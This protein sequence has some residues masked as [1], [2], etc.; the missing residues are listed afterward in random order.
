MPVFDPHGA[1]SDLLVGEGHPEVEIESSPGT[2]GEVSHQLAVIAKEDP[3][4]LG[5]GED[6]LAVGGVFEE[7]LL[8]PGRP[9]Q[10]PLL[11]AAW[12]QG[13]GLAAEAEPPGSHY[14]PEL[15]RERLWEKA[16]PLKPAEADEGSAVLAAQQTHQGGEADAGGVGDPRHREHHREAD[17][18]D[19]DSP[20]ALGVAAVE[21]VDGVDDLVDR[22][23]GELVAKD[24]DRDLLVGG[25]EGADS[26]EEAKRCQRLPKAPSRRRGA[27]GVSEDS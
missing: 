22:L 12:A 5:D 10:L 18:V 4:S 3:Q 17:G 21:A 15:A 9:Q 8:G 1:R 14:S 2:D 23:A 16:E 24:I 19:P 6:D 26:A 20:V 27:R 7:L 11:M 25:G 13:S